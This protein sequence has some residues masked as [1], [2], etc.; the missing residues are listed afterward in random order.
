MPIC[1]HCATP[2]ESLYMRYG[3]DHI[4]LS[5]CTSDI[6]STSSDTPAKSLS[7]PTGSGS[8]K[9]NAVVLA[10]EYLE[11]DLPI[12]IIDLILA[13]P[14]AYRHLLFNRSSIFAPPSTTSA[15]TKDGHGLSHS[16][17]LGWGRD[18][19]ELA[20]RIFALSLVD[21]YIRWFYMCVQPPL[22]TWAESEG[23]KTKLSEK[24]ASMVQMHLPIQ[25][26]IFFPSLFTPRSTSDLAIAT[27]CSATPL[28]TSTPTTQAEPDAVLSTLAVEATWFGSYAPS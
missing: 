28:F 19:W 4:V 27:V 5:P 2:I 25:A 12:V 15:A 11:H 14:Q 22:A 13:K 3:Q 23:G 16:K 6:C 10:D 17:G 24:L 1:I 9:A 8:S 26:G 7:T 21:A 20:K 18:V